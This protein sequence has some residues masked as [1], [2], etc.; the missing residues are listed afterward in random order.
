MAE[1]FFNAGH[2]GM[3]FFIVEEI[4]V[5]DADNK[6]TTKIIYEVLECVPEFEFTDSS[7]VA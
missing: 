7:F 3:Q 1:D 4:D 5:N 6:A 2:V